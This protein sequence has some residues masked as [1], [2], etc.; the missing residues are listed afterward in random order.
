MILENF[1][2]V[3]AA[4]ASTQIGVDDLECQ[5]AVVRALGPGVGTEIVVELE[6]RSVLWI[7]DPES[8]M[9]DL[10]PFE[11]RLLIDS[12]EQRLVASANDEMPPTPIRM[13]IGLVAS[14][15]ALGDDSPFP[16]RCAAA[17]IQ[18]F[19]DT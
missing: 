8:E 13:S 18:S 5:V 12:I 15:A 17:R 1:A 2:R 9:R 16:G 19:G 6:A 11:E 14:A 3:T 10:E 7:S 4:G